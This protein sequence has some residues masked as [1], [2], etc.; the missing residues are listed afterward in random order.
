MPEREVRLPQYDN[1]T[2]PGTA[3]MC[4]DGRYDEP[5]AFEPVAP[6][7]AVVPR[8]DAV[9]LKRTPEWPRGQLGAPPFTVVD[10][11]PTPVRVGER[12]CPRN[13]CRAATR[14]PHER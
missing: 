13:R 7:S 1:D 11:P 10:R 3:H 8:G 5:A 14:R 4:R 6:E 9:A 12:E 2:D